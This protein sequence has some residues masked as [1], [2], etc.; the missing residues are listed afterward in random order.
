MSGSANGRR[1][2]DNA[3]IIAERGNTNTDDIS[4]STN[5]LLHNMSLEEG[6][7][8]AGFSGKSPGQNIGETERQQAEGIMGP[9]QRPAAVELAAK[10]S[11]NPPHSDGVHA[12]AQHTGYSRDEF[13]MDALDSG[14]GDHSIDA[15]QFGEAQAESPWMLEQ[16]EQIKDD[17]ERRGHVD[18]SPVQEME[19]SARKQTQHIIS[20]SGEHDGV[21]SVSGSLTDTTVSSGMRSAGKESERVVSMG[22][23]FDSTDLG[24][25]E[26]GS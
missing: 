19:E 11:Q 1:W 22:R 21:L 14:H 7:G 8:I 24:S 13:T 26:P 23:K 4:L 6:S 12:R 20:G 5:L 10:G 16:I 18:Y 3:G 2:P 15:G 17:L 25:V 9:S